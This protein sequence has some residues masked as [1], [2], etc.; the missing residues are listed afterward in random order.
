VSRKN[1]I[2]RRII[3]EDELFK[4]LEI[5]HF[6]RV[7]LEELS[8]IEQVTLF[9]GAEK[10]IAVHGAGITNIIY[11]KKLHLIEFF[12]QERNIRDAFYFAQI[13]AALKFKHDVIEYKSVNLQQDIEIGENLYAEI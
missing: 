10:V 5:H 1:A 12:H 8:F 13:S 3:N 7:Y 9:Y 2:E 6:R 11:G 4:K